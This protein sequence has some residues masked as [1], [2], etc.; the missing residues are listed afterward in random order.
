MA[1]GGFVAP[2][3]RVRNDESGF[4]RRDCHG[5]LGPRLLVEERVQV[6][7]F[8]IHGR[9]GDGLDDVLGQILNPVDMSLEGTQ[10]YEFGVFVGRDKIPAGAAMARDCYGLPLGLL[11]VSPEVLGELG[12][13]HSN[14]LGLS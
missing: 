8:R 1:R 7:V 10:T 11:A 4:R 6:L 2:E 5:E 3:E 9:F 13:S 12:G 14:Y